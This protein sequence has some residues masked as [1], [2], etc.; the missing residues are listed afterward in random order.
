M[1]E[2]RAARGESNPPNSDKKTVEKNR[3]ATPLKFR[4]SQRP[5]SDLSTPDSQNGRVVITLDNGDLY[6]NREGDLVGN[7]PLTRYCIA[8]VLARLIRNDPLLGF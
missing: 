4:N 3:R 2:Y 6:F 8:E 1:A 7:D 5:R